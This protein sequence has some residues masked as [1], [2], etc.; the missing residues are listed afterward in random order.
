MD[1]RSVSRTVAVVTLAVAG[2]AS[3][4]PLIVT[5]NDDAPALQQFHAYTVHAGVAAATNA[6]LFATMA[7]VPAMIFAGR[8]ARRGA[9]KLAY[10]GAGISAMA[11][12]AGLTSLGA[13]QIGLYEGSRLPD[14]NGAAA[15]LDALTKNPVYEGLVLTFVLG[16]TVGMILLGIALWRSKAV[17]AWVG[18]LMIVYVLLHTVGHA[19]S[20]T[21]D[22]AAGIV[23]GVV[24][25][26]LAVTVARTPNAE[27]DLP[28]GGR[29]E[30]AAREKLL[31]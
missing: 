16:H 19:V 27:W 18:I 15:L 11:W 5:E 21:A 6:M 4:V 1:I 28:A 3:A 10:L 26:V 24:L 29:L 23:L 13:E 31:V 17:G 2:I 25:V 9:P 22:I 20:A 30:P 8:V 7:I 14:Q 12:L